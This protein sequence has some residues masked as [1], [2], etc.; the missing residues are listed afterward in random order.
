MG[1]SFLAADTLQGS[2]EDS[3]CGLI[4][5][6]CLGLCGPVTPGCPSGTVRAPVDPPQVPKGPRLLHPNPTT[7]P[8]DLL[9]CLLP[10]PKQAVAHQAASQ[11]EVPHRSCRCQACPHSGSSSHQKGQGLPK[12]GA[13]TDREQ[14]MGTATSPQDIPQAGSGVRAGLRA[15]ALTLAA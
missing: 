5:K 15:L 12:G 11:V 3:M 13:D 9:R 7:K 14:H 6:P 10:W 4:D 2:G 1:L 8:P